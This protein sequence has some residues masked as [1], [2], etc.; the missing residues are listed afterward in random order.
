MT[1]FNKILTGIIVIVIVVLGYL[2]FKS[3]KTVTQNQDQS[4]TNQTSSNQPTSSNTQSQQSSNN[5]QTANIDTSTVPATAIATFDTTDGSFQVTLDGK[6]APKTVANFIK[7]ANEGYYNGTKF[8]RIIQ[9][10]MIQ[11]GDPNSK[12][13][14]QST[15]GYGGPGYTVPAE[16]NLKANVGAIG[17]ASAGPGTPSS[18]SQFFIVTTESANNH[19][20]LDGN[21]TFFGYV[22]SGMNIVTKIAATP[23]KASLNNPAEISLPTQD[24]VINKITIK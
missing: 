14:D 1:N 2:Y 22:T 13:S 9:D 11:G 19:A 7:L 16:I 15:Y 21:Y 4:Q 10:F 8:H 12:G 6:T 5:Q 3:N 18:G 23:V 20:S 17:M 24:V